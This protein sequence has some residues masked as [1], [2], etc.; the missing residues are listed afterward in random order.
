[1]ENL[2]LLGDTR[3]YED[4]ASTRRATTSMLL[5]LRQR[6]LANAS[7]HY[8]DALAD[9]VRIAIRV[10][11]ASPQTILGVLAPSVAN[12]SAG[13]GV[14]AH[15]LCADAAAEAAASS[16][17]EPLRR[18]GAS[19]VTVRRGGGADAIVHAAE[20]DVFFTAD[21]SFSAVAAALSLGV[22]VAVGS[23]RNAVGH[24]GIATRAPAWMGEF[25]CQLDHLRRSRRRLR[26]V[27]PPPQAARGWEPIGEAVRRARVA[28]H[29][30]RPA[31]AFERV[32]VAAARLAAARAPAGGG[33]VARD[34]RVASRA[35]A[36]D[37]C[38]PAAAVRLRFG[39][40]AAAGGAST[41]A[42]RRRGVAIRQSDVPPPR[43]RPEPERTRLGAPRSVAP[44]L[45]HCGGH[46]PHLS[47][48]R[49][50]RAA[51]SRCVRRV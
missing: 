46:E 36:A 7:L 5:A 43:Q 29:A 51:Q 13:G 38:E 9:D 23:H 45:R 18:A 15:L 41:A 34:V 12:A 24:R 48:D 17:T 35:I 16:W 44:P 39:R 31:G 19:T 22:H 30:H 37:D 14:H 1:M 25:A 40:Y 2:E 50:V 49:A 6:A 11:T 33:S 27:A 28:A 42:R 20:A 32:G 3:A 10:G 21:D 26:A 4:T 8:A 47:R